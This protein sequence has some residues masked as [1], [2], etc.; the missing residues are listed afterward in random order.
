MP[1]DARLPET[2]EKCES[3]FN[4]AIL[5]FLKKIRDIHV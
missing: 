1:A 4:S 5:F 2:K 3:H